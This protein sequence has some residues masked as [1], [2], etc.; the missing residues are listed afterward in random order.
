MSEERIYL[1]TIVGSVSET[2]VHIQE[3]IQAVRCFQ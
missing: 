3:G 1:V 2:E